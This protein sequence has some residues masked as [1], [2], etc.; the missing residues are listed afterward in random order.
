MLYV[1]YRYWYDADM[2]LGRSHITFGSLVVYW[3]PWMQ[4]ITHVV[5]CLANLSNVHTHTHTH[6]QPFYGFVEFVRDNPGE[7]VP[8]R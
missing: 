2:T 4:C 7:P 8:E 3:A 1:L 6:T 5:V